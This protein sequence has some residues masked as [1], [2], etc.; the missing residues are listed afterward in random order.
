LFITGTGQKHR[1][2]PLAPIYSVLG[3]KKAAALPG[4][5]V[6]SGADVTG[7]F[8]GKGK[9]TF[10]KVFKELD[11]SND[12]V[13]GLTMLGATDEPTE[14]VLS[15]IEKF[16]CKVYF[17]H[18]DLSNVAEVRWWLFKKKQAQ[19]ESLPP[20]K[21]ALQSA[22]RRAHYQA[23]IWNNDIVPNP[24]LPDPCSF[25]CIWLMA[26]TNQSQLLYLQPQKE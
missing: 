20:T 26:N 6:I 22:I 17:P 9:T 16:T 25:G 4:L 2:I 10:W 13:T 5:H 21:A 8:A 18:T 24:E 3:A 15:S 14:Q 1:K 23:M 11:S 19:S 7:R 12:L